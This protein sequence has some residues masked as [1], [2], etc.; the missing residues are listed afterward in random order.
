MRIDFLFVVLCLSTS[1]GELS[2]A[3]KS[4]LKKDVVSAGH[5]HLFQNLTDF[6]ENQ[7]IEKLLK[8]TQ[9]V[10]RRGDGS[11]LELKQKDYADIDPS[12][13]WQI[14]KE[15]WNLV[16]DNKPVVNYTSDYAGAVPK[17]ISDWTQLEHWK[18]HTTDSYD[19]KFVN[20]I[21]M[22][23][24]EFS[25]VFNFKYGAD[26]NGTGSYVTQAGASVTNV[27]AYLTEHV[28][29]VVHAF[30]PL[31]YGSTANPVAG[32]DIEVKMTSYGEFEK[33]TVGCHIMAKGD[34]SLKEITCDKGTHHC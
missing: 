30:N 29:V 15:L 12:Q 18:D 22:R 25:W 26:L 33:T 21:N 14:G 19:I 6:E 23:L 32:I 3:Q 28:D 16:Q 20:F 10:A 24:T 11:H 31:N 17:G 9:F 27:Y 7:M 8:P 4:Q 1:N 2:Q 13:I 34:G 5:G